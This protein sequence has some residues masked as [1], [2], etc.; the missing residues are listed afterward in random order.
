[1]SMDVLNKENPYLHQYVRI[2]ALVEQQ[3][4][5]R[6]TGRAGAG[7]MGG[8]C[9]TSTAHDLQGRG[10]YCWI[11]LVSMISCTASH[12][13]YHMISHSS[14]HTC[15]QGDAGNFQHCLLFS[16]SQKGKLFLWWQGCQFFHLPNTTRQKCVDSKINQLTN[17][18]KNM[19]VNQS[20]HGTEIAWKWTKKLKMSN[21]NWKVTVKTNQQKSDRTKIAKK[22]FLKHWCDGVGPHTH[23]SWCVWHRVVPHVWQHMTSPDEA[24]REC[25][26]TWWCI[27]W[28]C[29]THLTWKNLLMNVVTWL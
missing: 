4:H 20:C 16:L 10:F 17:T 12:M 5:H 11:I 23:L 8:S 19:T 1:M 26:F 18:N 6:E 14:T 22:F 13:W 15:V 27:T 25:F 24:L 21:W 3:L 29:M 7:G 28:L 2:T 9:D